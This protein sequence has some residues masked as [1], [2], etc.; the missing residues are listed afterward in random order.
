MFSTPQFN[1][2][3]Y[4]ESSI[5][6]VLSTLMRQSGICMYMYFVL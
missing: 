5:V 6:F 3:P 4:K 1:C 2:V